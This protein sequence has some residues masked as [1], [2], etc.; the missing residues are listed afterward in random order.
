M[1]QVYGKSGNR[2]TLMIGHSPGGV[3]ASDGSRYASMH[4]EVHDEKEEAKRWDEEQKQEP[5]QGFDADP[6]PHPTAGHVPRVQRDRDCQT[7]KIATLTQLMRKPSSTS[8][9]GGYI[10]VAPLAAGI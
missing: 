10:K 2:L 3:L 7:R 8:T 6:G 5:P 1:L 4:H 9:R